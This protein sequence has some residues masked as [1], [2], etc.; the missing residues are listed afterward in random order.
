MDILSPI[1]YVK[2]V[3]PRRAALLAKLG[4]E[5]ARDALFYLPA[6]YEDRSS[7]NKIVHLSVGQVR[8]VTG[9]VIKA[10]V[11]PASPRKPRLKIFTVVISDGSG[12]L[13]AKWFNQTYLG[14]LFKP[15]QRVI[16]YGTV[17]ANY[18][19]SGFEMMNPEFEIIDEEDDDSEHIH[20]GR[21]VPV[22]GLTEGLSQR[23]LRSIIH[24]T[25]IS[26]LA[27]VSD[28]MP[29]DIIKRL[30]L[31]GLKESLEAVHFPPSET[32]MQDLL[33]GKS[34]FHQRLAFDELFTLQLGLA[35][36]KNRGTA[37]KGISFAPTGRLT[38]GLMERLPF[39]LTRAQQRV[40]EDIMKDMRS[41]APMN[42]LIQ[43]DVG[44]GKTV[45]AFLAMLA[46]VE[47]GYQAA[48]MAPTEI[49]AEQHCLNIH[50]MAEQL[51]LRVHLLTGSK[52]EKDYDAIASGASD[53]VIGTHA[54]IQEGVSF[55]KLGLIVIDE[56]HRFGVIQR[57]Q[58]RKKG[59]NPD[60]LIMTATPIPRTLALT[61]YGDLDYSLIDE[62][63]PNRTPVTTKVI[64]E[65]QKNIIY[66]MIDKE[67]KEGRQVYVVYPLIE[68]SDKSNL[69]DAITGMEGLQK[70]FPALRVSLI[71][72][73]MQ[74]T[75]REDIMR[76]FKEGS[77]Q[78]LVSTTVIE[79][80]VDVPNATLM[81]IIHAERFG[82]SQ[83]HQLRGRVGR[84]AGKSHCLLL[85]YGGSLDA[86]KRLDVM[87]RT[88]DGFIIAEKDLEIRGPGEFF[89]TKQ[90]G[91]PDLRAA[92]LLRDYKL[93]EI[94]RKEAFVLIEKDPS[95][96]SQKQ[97]RKALEDF[98]G[99]KLELFKT[100]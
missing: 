70:K 13:S 58:L 34:L 33:T 88:N 26:S 78:I 32:P 39:S 52:K 93:L 89:G 61:L 12:A 19:G 45:V 67:A 92:N 50:A 24:T 51:G 3:G 59:M 27:S 21:I 68:E 1:Q 18:W 73:R 22:Y 41:P 82:L 87:A 23:Q 54:L 42:R 15:S 38:G 7:I 40:V 28:P 80:G 56:Q 49:L 37:E 100:A 90:S 91:L 62:L 64:R 85:N 25:L 43:G 8:A 17:K 46:A 84:G 48:L 30:G 55:K 99:K 5:T 20:T 76:E 96:S 2:G 63:P 9:K 75:E 44:C 72:G 16:F 14:R 81:I 65:S 53:I 69:R 35:A 4:I 71:H 95:L 77:I 47:S 29:E 79:V 98:W 74:A 6:R 94:A 57:A 36:L 83:L 86:M 97:L 31:P 60:T 11:V 10:E 66:E